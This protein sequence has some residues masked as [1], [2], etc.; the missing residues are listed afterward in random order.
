MLSPVS[1]FHSRSIGVRE[2]RGVTWRDV[3]VFV[4]ALRLASE[5]ELSLR[6]HIT[7]RAAKLTFYIICLRTA[8]IVDELNHGV[9]V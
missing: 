6:A 1:T 8:S 4:T 7:F 9:I 3:A 5:P 2:W